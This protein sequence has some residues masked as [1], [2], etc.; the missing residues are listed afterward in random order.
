MPQRVC[1]I[2]AKLG[3]GGSA[4]ILAIAALNRYH[5]GNMLADVPAPPGEVSMSVELF[6]GSAR[7]FGYAAL[8]VAA[9]V[10]LE[11]LTGHLA[12]KRLYA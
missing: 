9:V 8:L 10:A 3:L 4:T 12:K 6:A 5:R 1:L 2:A 11:Y 7:F